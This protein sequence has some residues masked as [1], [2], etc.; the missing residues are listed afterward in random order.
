MSHE[1]LLRRGQGSRSFRVAGLDVHST[2][3]ALEFARL[4]AAK[5]ALD[6]LD[7]E[8]PG[9]GRQNANNDLNP[10]LTARLHG[11]GERPSP[12]RCS[13]DGIAP[14]RLLSPVRWRADDVAT[15]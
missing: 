7:H 8:R 6:T 10:I 9:R 14:G 13:D 12:R 2:R 15:R 4:V 5:I 11:Q 1:T 3:G